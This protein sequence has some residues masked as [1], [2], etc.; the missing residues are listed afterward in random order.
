MKLRQLGRLL[1]L[2]LAGSPLATQ[3]QQAALPVIAVV[4]GGGPDESKLRAFRQ[5]LGELGFVEGRSVIISYRWAYTRYEQLPALA[6]EAVRDRP[7]VIA[8]NFPAVLSIKALT[9]SIPIVFVTGGDPV[10]QG[11]VASLNRPGGNITGITNLNAE[12]VPKRMQLLADVT[13]PGASLAMLMNPALPAPGR[14]REA[15]AKSAASQLGRELQILYASS[16]QEFEAAFTQLKA[17]RPG[18]LVISTDAAYNSLGQQLGRWAA[19]SE[20]PAIFQYRE[21]V[22]AGGLMSY[23]GSATEWARLQ[24]VYAGRILKGD[25]PADLPVQ[26]ATR[27]ELTINLKAAKDLG[28]SIPLP[29][30]GRADEV[31]E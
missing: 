13:P 22:Q 5:G 27:V 26:Q 6:A 15:E 21:F 28:I 23:G 3:A 2:T 7:S 1:A 25:K 19:R 12:L 29:L 9:P 20:L 31:I 4:D 16:E 24:G 10:R 17:L 8:T 11:L 14:D 30:L 18:G